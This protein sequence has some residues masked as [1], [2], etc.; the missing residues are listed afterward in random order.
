VRQVVTRH[1]C[2]VIAKV[3]SERLVP[4][5]DPAS[6]SAHTGLVGS[7]VGVD[8]ISVLDLVLGLEEELRIE[9]DE[10]KLNS[11]VLASV[12]SLARHLARRMEPSDGA[13]AASDKTE[14]A[15]SERESPSG[16]GEAP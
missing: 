2:G 7:G 16:G 8:S 6:V 10:S 14:A 5:L 11:E 12:G 15:S 9:I 4:G 1:L 13:E 3:I